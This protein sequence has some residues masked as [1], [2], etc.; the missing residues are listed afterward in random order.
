MNVRKVKYKAY[1][2]AIF[3]FASDYLIACECLKLQP[4]LDN[5]NKET[6]VSRIMIIDHGNINTV[7]KENSN[8]DLKNL[9]IPPQPHPPHNFISYT[10]IAVVENLLGEQKNDTLIFLNDY[11]GTCGAHLG[12]TK[13]G[14]EFVIRY[15]EVKID[16]ADIEE[17]RQFLNSSLKPVTASDC[18]NWKLT[19]NNTKAIGNIFTSKRAK[20]LQKLLD[21]GEEFTEEELEHKI[22]HIKHIKEDKL[23]Y[24]TLI[25]KLKEIKH[26]LYKKP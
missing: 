24:I 5:I 14:R 17:I 9:S 6:C 4:F 26:T 1:L 12:F 23:E 20:N 22:E 2:I 10:K 25:R 13:I 15:N 3:L 18:I 21:D 11:K 19:I 16:H 7:T 8:Y